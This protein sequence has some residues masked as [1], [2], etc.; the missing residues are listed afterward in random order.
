MAIAGWLVLFL[1]KNGVLL[2]RD[3]KYP[4]VGSTCIKVSDW[5]SIAFNALCSIF[6]KLIQA[7]FGLL[8]LL[9]AQGFYGTERSVLFSP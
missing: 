8:R 1:L 3:N 4:F 7:A 9:S 2:A 5:F 6:Y